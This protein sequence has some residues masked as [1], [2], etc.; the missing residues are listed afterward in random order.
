MYINLR[1]KRSEVG[2]KQAWNNNAIYS[3]KGLEENCFSYISCAMRAGLI[4]LSLLIAEMVYSRCI[5]Q[6]SGRK[7]YCFFELPF[8]SCKT[9]NRK[10]NYLDRKN[11]KHGRINCMLCTI[12]CN[13]EEHRSVTSCPFP[14]LWRTDRPTDQAIDRPSSRPTISW[15]L[16]I[17]DKLH[18]QKEY[19]EKYVKVRL[20]LSPNY[21]SIGTK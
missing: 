3:K 21:C 20:R 12:N 5:H 13:N 16:G 8:N 2:N 14:K 11:N 6:S 1:N 10:Q 18:F 17:I 9:I 4:N 15:I 7:C 19:R